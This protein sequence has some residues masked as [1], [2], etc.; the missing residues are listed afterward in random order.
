M[1][2]HLMGAAGALE[3]LVTVMAV[4]TGDIPPTANL[5]ELDASCA[6]L[7][8]VAGSG[9]RGAGVPLALSNSFAFGGSN[10]VLVFRRDGSG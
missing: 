10:M 5:S 4:H 7:D 9:R 8:H 2:G 1:H 3:A 6:G